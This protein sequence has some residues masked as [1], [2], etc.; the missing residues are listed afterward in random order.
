MVQYLG[1]TW[2]TMK[3]MYSNNPYLPQVRQAAAVFARGHGVRTAARRY[4]CSPGTITKWMQKARRVGYHPIPTRSS[5]PHR[6]PRA[7]PRDVVAAVITER[8][9]RRRCAEHVHHALSQKGVSVSLS[10]VKRILDRCG[11]RRKRSPRKRLHDAT[12]RPVAEAPGALLQADTVH[13]RLPD[14]SRL[15]VY[16][17]IDLFSRWAYAE[18]VERITA[19]R[20]V[21][22]VRRAQAVAPFRFEMVQTDHG[23]EF[24]KMFR[25]R[26]A[27][28]GVA[29]R[30]SR[31]RQANDN[32][33]VERF[34]RTLQE[35]CLDRVAH[36]LRSFRKALP[37]YLH[38][39]NE[40]RSHMGIGFKTPNAL[41]FPRC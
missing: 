12:P 11:L 15:Y 6:S 3:T 27:K 32:A 19:A 5:R 23:P 36:S 14:G 18:V 22:F 41:V 31:V 25:Y 35:E 29:H 10:S 4:G 38:W 24:Q 28:E 9:G 39:Y 2:H 16:T 20:S 34:N 13:F 33:H 37:G 7:L 8:T 1:N 40:E 17:L 26:L 21:T 30:Y